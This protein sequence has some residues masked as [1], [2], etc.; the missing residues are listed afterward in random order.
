MKPEEIFSSSYAAAA[1]LSSIHFKKKAYVVGEVGILEELDLVGV[2]H[3]GGP[4]DASKR[5]ELTPGAFM[6]H[7][8]DVGA[9]IVGFD[10]NINYYKIQA[11][12]GSS[13]PLAPVFRRVV[14]PLAVFMCSASTHASV[15]LNRPPVIRPPCS[16]SVSHSVPR[17]GSLGRPAPAHKRQRGQ[18]QQGPRRCIAC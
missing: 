11:R 9:V 13:A 8:P 10:R 1:Y 2:S 14:W 3:L 15:S 5:V 17:E 12:G 4:G 18:G 7:D 6:K 16:L